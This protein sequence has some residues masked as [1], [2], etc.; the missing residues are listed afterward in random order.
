MNIRKSY[1]YTNNSF[2]QTKSLILRYFKIRIFKP[3]KSYLYTKNSYLYTK[4]NRIFN[5]IGLKVRI[6]KI[7]FLNQWFLQSPQNKEFFAGIILALLK[8]L[9]D[10]LLKDLLLT[11]SEGRTA[12][13]KA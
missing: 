4:R 5:P 11:T 9:K 10:L 13:G 2:H 1:L 7:V 6:I 3:A 8:T 12:N